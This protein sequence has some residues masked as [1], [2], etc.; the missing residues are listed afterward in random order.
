MMRG[1]A[2]TWS[3]RKQP[4]V[5]LSTKE[6]EFVAACACVCQAIW[7]MMIL[8][9]IGHSQIEGTKLMCDN[10]STFKVS[11]NSILHGHPKHINL[12]FCDT[13]NQLADLLTKP[14]QITSISKVVLTTGC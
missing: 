14:L 11:K 7:M 10:T 1:G 4:I 12:L 6:V 2:A 5:T 8:K 13:R 9:E 3:S